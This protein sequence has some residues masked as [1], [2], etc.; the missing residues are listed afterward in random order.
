M[1]SGQSKLHK[2]FT[3]SI[4]THQGQIQPCLL[5]LV[6]PF[7]R[8]KPLKCNNDLI[9]ALRTTNLTEQKDTLLAELLIANM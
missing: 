9:Q 8:R 3:Q 4:F 6:C 7:L 2:R 1:V 5:A